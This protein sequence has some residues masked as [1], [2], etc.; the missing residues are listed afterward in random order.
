[1]SFNRR[2]FWVWLFLKT[3]VWFR[4]SA[5]NNDSLNWIQKY[6][7]LIEFFRSIVW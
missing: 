3:K 1:M 4:L 7:Y 2:Y 6:R 5:L